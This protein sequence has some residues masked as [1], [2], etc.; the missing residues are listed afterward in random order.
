MSWMSQLVNTY[1][2]NT[3]KEKQSDI[4]LMPIAHMSANAQIE[5]TLSREGEFRNAVKVEK[6]DAATLIPVTEASA[7][8]AS[9][10]APHALSDTLSYIAGDFSSYCESE[11]EKKSTEDKFQSYMENLKKWSESVYSHPKVQAVYAY[12]TKKLIIDDL[13]KEGLVELQE[14]GVFD[15]KK[16][17]G[18]PYE[19]VMVRFR[20]LSE[21]PEKT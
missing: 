20:V 18:Q 8:R 15:H 21:G 17:S 5:I 10:I 7:G 6:K 2:N 3:A 9:G 14:D 4:R 12:L 16:I 19:K 1:E 11:K 13:I